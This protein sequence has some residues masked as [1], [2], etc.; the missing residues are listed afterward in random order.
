[1]NDMVREGGCRCGKVRFE[2]KGQP[3]I[4][5]ACHCKNCQRMTSS[6]FSLSEGYLA[7]QFRVTQGEA[8]IGGIHGPVRHYCCDYCKSWLF[9]EMPDVRDFVN[10]RTTLFDESSHERPFIETFVDEGLLWAR[11]G[12]AHSFGGLPAMERWPELM[13]EFAKGQAAVPEEANP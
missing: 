9:T 12:A 7:S 5:M 11:T 13:H 4:S 2:A 3:I 8:V 10:V 6:A 1:M